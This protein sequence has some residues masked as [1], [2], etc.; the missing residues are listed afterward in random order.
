MTPPAALSPSPARVTPERISA[1]LLAAAGTLPFLAAIADVTGI[2]AG[3]RGAGWPGSGWLGSGWLAPVQIYGALIAS[4]VCGIHW[5]A[6]LFAPRGLAVSLLFAS[7]VGALLAWLAALL[8]PQPGFLLL[9]AIFAGL[10][11]IDRH[12]RRAGLWHAWF[13]TLRLAI[14]AAVVGACLW[15]GLAV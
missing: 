12:L 15:I 13:W 4:F 3:W 2:G 14:S 1:W 11:A 10:L 8:P 9:A 7:N 5:G 6:A